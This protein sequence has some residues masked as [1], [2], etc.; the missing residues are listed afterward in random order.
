[1]KKYIALL[2]AVVIASACSSP[3]YTYHF[4]YYDYNSGKKKTQ[5]QEVIVSEEQ[6]AAE[7]TIIIDEETLVASAKETDL[8]VAKP[9]PFITKEEAVARINT[10]SKEERKE[11]KREIKKYVKEN[12]KDIKEGKA[13]KAMAG[14][15]KLAAIF[16]VVGIV[17][18]IVLGDLFW[19]GTIAILIG[20]FFL[21]RYL[22]NN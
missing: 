20:L 4:D 7:P 15:L 22:I 8:Y 6:P 13:A 9:A 10:L 19:I 14:D 21:V 5:K 11:L 16:G 17:L 3:K 2:I 18:V 12:K 1:M